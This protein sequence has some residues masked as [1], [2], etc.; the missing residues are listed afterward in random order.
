MRKVLVTGG[1]GYIG[2]HTV[3]ELIEAGY[4]PVIIDNFSNSEPWIIDRIEEITKTKPT[5]YEGDC[6]NKDFLNEVFAEEKEIDSVIHFAAMKSAHE[7]IANPLE[8]YKNNLCS[9]LAL[10]EVMSQYKVTKL[11]FSSSA[12]VYG[13]SDINPIPETAE[14]KNQTSTYGTTKLMCESIIEDV[15]KSSS[16]KAISLRYFNPVG[17]HASALIGELPKGTPNNLVPYITQTAIGLREYL[18]VYGDDYPTMDGTCIRD[19]I[20]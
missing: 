1:V 10:L 4:V 7:S 2:S 17:A 11:V 15:A 12:T 9:T 14:L 20:H 8:Y 18:T 3:V 16:L 6:G 19:F 5:F 13:E